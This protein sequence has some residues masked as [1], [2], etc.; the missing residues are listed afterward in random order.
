[1]QLRCEGGTAKHAG[2]GAGRD[3]GTVVAGEMPGGCSWRRFASQLIRPRG[4]RSARRARFGGS[5]GGRAC[6]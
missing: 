1:V 5:A 3:E 2:V 6:G 4:W